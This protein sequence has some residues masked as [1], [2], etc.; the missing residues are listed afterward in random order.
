MTTEPE[1]TPEPE[2]APEPARKEQRPLRRLY[3]GGA[4]AAVVGSV[5]VC[6]GAVFDPRQALF[7]YL[8]AC[9]FGFTI[10]IGALAFSMTA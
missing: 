4:A 1:P 10:A 5:L 6:V 9:A 2:K 3:L 8:V 7:S